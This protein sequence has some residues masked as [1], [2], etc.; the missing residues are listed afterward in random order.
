MNLRG[1]LPKRLLLAL[2]AT[3]V[4][5]VLAEAGLR[6][7]F[8][9]RGV[10][11]S[12]YLELL[13]LSAQAP[14]EEVEAVSVFGI[15]EP[16]PYPDVVYQLRPNLRGT[17]RGE[18]FATNRFGLRGPDV[19]RTK[20]PGTFRVVGLGD[21]FMFGWGVAQD[22]VYGAQLERLFA[23]S[24][25][26]VEFLNFGVPGYN[27]T[28]EVATYEHRARHFDP[29][30]V[31]VHFVGNDLALPHHLQ[32]P[33]DL[34]PSNWYLTELVAA[35]L[36]PK[37][38][39]GELELLPHDITGRPDEEEITGRYGYML[40]PKGY[41]RAMA[42]LAELTRADGVPVVVMSQG[43]RELV[44]QEAERHGFET[45]DPSPV[46]VERIEADGTVMTA[47]NW[48]GIWRSYLQ[49]PEDI[50]PSPFAHAGYAEAIRRFLVAR[51]MPRDG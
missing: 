1:A 15:V 26:P 2:C 14:T 31:L 47:E 20:A 8:W 9:L 29:D 34:R 7:Y 4:A 40:G 45:L 33:R 22:V 49:L 12:D 21:S 50:H 23:G 28:M 38:L 30:L 36:A 41:R 39:D 24:P 5:L 42:K 51:G 19:E 46:F 16:S 37:G 43:L 11:R 10:G 35:L 25:T 18:P 6:G 44:S 48:R 3:L 17:F 13:R 32:P 27:T